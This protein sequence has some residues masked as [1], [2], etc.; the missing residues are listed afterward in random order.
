VLFYSD[1]GTDRG[2]KSRMGDRVI[3]GGKGFTT[4]AGMHVPL[5]AWSPGLVK[6]GRVCR[7]LID[8][9]DFIPTIAEATGTTW[10]DNKPLDGR[11]FLPQIRGEAG[12]PKEWL[13]SHWDPHPG[14]KVDFKPTRLAWDH[15]WKLYLDGRL[16]RYTEDPL[17][18]R[19]VTEGSAALAARKKLQAALDKMAKVKAPVFNKFAT[20]GRPAY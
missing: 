3:P 15:D 11:S 1:N 20:D 6:G 8:S 10:F 5:I 2:L 13:F 16:Y 4:D 19:P 9:T 12:K 17:E 14:C 7:D 18:E